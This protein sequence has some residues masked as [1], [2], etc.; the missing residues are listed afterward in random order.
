MH[1]SVSF[2][3]PSYFLD[4]LVRYFYKYSYLRPDNQFSLFLRAL[5]LFSLPVPEC[6]WEAPTL[7]LFSLLSVQKLGTD[8]LS[9]VF[10]LPLS[11]SS[12]AKESSVSLG[13]FLS[14]SEAEIVFELDKVLDANSVFTCDEDSLLSWESTL[15]TLRSFP[16]CFSPLSCAVLLMLVE[17]FESLLFCRS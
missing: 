4:F 14:F 3:P 2:S 13:M 7:R 17:R 11:E 5:S 12:L 1:I 9:S 15:G 6:L 10:V 16:S 8:F